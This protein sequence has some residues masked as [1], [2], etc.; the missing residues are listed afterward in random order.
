MVAR[1]Q[2]AVVLE[3]RALPAGRL[4]DAQARGA[5]HVG[6]QHAVEGLHEHLADVAVQ[7]LVEDGVQEAAVVRRLHAAAAVTVPGWAVLRRRPDL[8]DRDQLDEAGAELVAEEA[9]DLERVAGVGGES[10]PR[11]IWASG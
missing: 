2:V 10:P 1:V 5:A 7:P 11:F 3:R 6:G 4:E 8:D 9:V